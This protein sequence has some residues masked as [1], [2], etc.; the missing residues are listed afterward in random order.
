MTGNSYGPHLAYVRAY[1]LMLNGSS[2]LAPAQSYLGPPT[3]TTGLAVLVGADA[4]LEMTQYFTNLPERSNHF[5]FTRMFSPML[6][7]HVS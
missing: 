5:L 7:R 3:T 4:G 2:A 6:S 1:R